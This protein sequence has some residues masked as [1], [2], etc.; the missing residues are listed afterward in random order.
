MA[1]L[2]IRLARPPCRQLTMTLFRALP[3]LTTSTAPVHAES[4]ALRGSRAPLNVPSE[5]SRSSAA[6]QT[7]A[8]PRPPTHCRISVTIALSQIQRGRGFPERYAARTGRRRCNDQYCSASSAN[9]I[10]PD[11]SCHRTLAAEVSRMHEKR[12]RTISF[13]RPKACTR[14]GFRARP[15]GQTPRLRTA[16]RRCGSTDAP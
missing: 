6:H 15:R 13:R 16:R 11:S 4:F 10:A 9:R 7:T 12:V 5:H 2:L 3:W 1:L 14:Y 8:S